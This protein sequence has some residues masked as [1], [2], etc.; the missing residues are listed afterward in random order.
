MGL[1]LLVFAVSLGLTLVLTPIA[2]RIALN[3]GAVDI[4]SKRKVHTKVI[5]RFGG[6]AIFISFLCSVLLGLGFAD[7]FGIKISPKDVHSLIGIIVGGG[8]IVII[9][10]IDDMRGLSASVKLLGQ[11]TAS[12]IAVYFGAKILLVST[13]FSHLI[14]LGAWAPFVTIMWMVAITNAMNLIDGLDG[15]ASGITAI[16]AATLS[17]VALKMGQSDS[18]LIL[19]ALTGASLGFLRYNFYPASIF[20]GDS[21]SLFLGFM[22]AAASIVGVLKST[23]VIALIVPVIVLGIP[24]YDTAS[25]IIRRAIAR[26][27]IFEADKK[28]IHHR[29][30]NVGFNQRQVVLI[31]YMACFIL[32]LAALAFTIFENYQTLIFLSLL[33]VAGILALDLAKDM[34]RSFATGVKRTKKAKKK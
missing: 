26:R 21:G 33:V 19:I 12:V 16:A 13:P 5:T 11:I 31:I 29:L 3:V 10:L 14:M 1:Y 9:G 34:L 4:P 7:Q 23:L 6:L 30:L 28:H 27:S 20:L 15:L 22:L 17:V 18:A 24:I 32:S 8:L 2:R 25:A